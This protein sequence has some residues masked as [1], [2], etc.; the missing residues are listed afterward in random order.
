MFQPQHTSER[1][2]FQHQSSN[3]ANTSITINAVSN[4]RHVIKHLVW[5]VDR[6]AIAPN[7]VHLEI[8]NSTTNTTLLR[9]GINDSGVGT[10]HFEAHGPESGINEAM[11]I[12]ITDTG[13]VQENHVNIIYQ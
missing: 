3:T 10:I 6:E 5:S 9:F 2:K 11:Q 4:E 7:T 13:A 1:V 8:R 12:F